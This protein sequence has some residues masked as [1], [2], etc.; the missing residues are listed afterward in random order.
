MTALGAILATLGSMIWEA[1]LV[2]RGALKQ[3]DPAVAD[4]KIVVAVECENDSSAEAAAKVLAGRG[5]TLARRRNEDEQ[6]ED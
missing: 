5:I 6:R 1:R 3:Y 4:G 2:R